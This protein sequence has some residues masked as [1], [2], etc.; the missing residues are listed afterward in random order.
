MYSKIPSAQ[1]AKKAVIDSVHILKLQ[2]EGNAE[3][4]DYIATG[5]NKTKK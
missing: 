3:L 5:K 2:K 4:A 1:P